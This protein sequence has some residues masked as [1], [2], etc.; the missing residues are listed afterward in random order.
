MGLWSSIKKV[1]SGI[2]KGIKSVGSSL[3][4]GLTGSLSSIPGAL[5]GGAVDLGSSWLGNK[6]I[7]QPNADEAYAQSKEASA[8]AFDRSYGAYKKRY[9]DTMADMEK[10]GLN[11]ILAA[12][13]GFNVGG[14]PE[15]TAAKSFMPSYQEQNA[16]TAYQMLTS[17]D[18]NKQKAETEQID[19][20]K[21][22]EEALNIAQDT[23]KKY[24]ETVLIKTENRKKATEIKL[25][26]QEIWNKVAEFQK[27]IAESYSSLSQTEVNYAKVEEIKAH[28]QNLLKMVD[29]LELEMSELRQHAE[30]YKGIPGLLLKSI[31]EAITAL[32]PFAK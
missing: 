2:F 25:L 11:P 28:E 32:S 22:A 23:W 9:Q 10:A 24:Q 3:I 6:L 12:S 27:I 31:K 15:M 30:I 17:G 13:Q 16:S 26:K 7:G 20:K 1:G 21:K 19:R 18:L 29:K 5:L 14:Q 8:K 4:G